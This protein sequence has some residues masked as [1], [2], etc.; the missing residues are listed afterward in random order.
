MNLI[1]LK[2]R[3]MLYHSGARNYA[4]DMCG[5]KF[6]QMEHLKRHMQSIHNVITNTS[7]SSNQTQ[8]SKQQTTKSKSKPAKTT[9]QLEQQTPLQPLPL[10][11]SRASQP[12]QE[13][14]EQEQK[15]PECKVTSRCMYKC[16]QCDYSTRNLYSLNEHLIEK[17][18]ITSHSNMSQLISQEIHFD[19]SFSQEDLDEQDEEDE[20]EVSDELSI[21]DDILNELTSIRIY[22]CSFCIFSTEKKR[23][24]KV[25]FLFF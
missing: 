25:S 22:S 14:Q 5:N 8:T 18:S 21:V 13:I 6:F 11:P 10:P 12:S 24:L 20:D 7:S 9:E 16:Q 1:L 2:K 15:S 3:H 4:C 17:H 19:T 23:N